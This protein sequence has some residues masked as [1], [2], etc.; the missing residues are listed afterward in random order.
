LLTHDKV[1]VLSLGLGEWEGVSETMEERSRP[2]FDL[3]V[4][5]EASWQDPVFT[6][7]TRITVICLRG[8]TVA[9]GLG[10]SRGR[11]GDLDRL[12]RVEHIARIGPVSMS[13]VEQLLDP[14]VSRWAIATLMAGGLLGERGGVAV[15]DALVELQPAVEGLLRDLRQRQARDRRQFAPHSVLH[16]EQ[17]D[18]LALGLE[19]SGL[20][21]RPIV[22]AF[23]PLPGEPYL[24]FQSAPTASEASILRHD[25]QNF[26]GWQRIDGQVH[27][28][29]H[30]VDPR[31]SARRVTAFYADKEGLERVTGT[32]LIYYTHH[33]PGF[34]LV[35]YKRLVREGRDGGA[36]AAV[37][38]PDAQLREE[39]R[40]MRSFS[41]ARMGG[42]VATWRLHSGPFY[43]KLVESDKQR[44]ETRRLV[45]GMYFP[46]DLFEMLIESP[47][48]LGPK[49]G[50]R[51]SWDNAERYLS[52]TEFV[53]LVQQGWIGSQG[54][55]TEAILDV[56]NALVG[57]GHGVL[58]VR[59]D[60]DTSRAQPI[61]RG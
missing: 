21:S 42:S 52:N 3:N 41:D 36:G 5:M 57:E 4:P 45:S 47:G 60:T 25:I 58:V 2:Y 12:V 31:D 43:V 26:E 38:R 33:V 28:V 11:S 34:V 9:L 27:D 16:V 13:Q 50:R 17:R 22:D 37:Y 56:V 20:D 48:V 39:I 1:A 40:R 44:P 49:G 61:R 18:A 32:D 10:R 15:L 29:V 54:D 46:L 14:R 55:A 53:N 30:F 7:T 23:A 24:S 19:M 51:I 8:G 6:A 35:Q 59:N